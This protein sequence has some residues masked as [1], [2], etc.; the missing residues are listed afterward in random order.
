MSAPQLAVPKTSRIERKVKTPEFLAQVKLLR[1]EAAV[2]RNLEG[3]KQQRYV[4]EPRGTFNS[5]GD[6]RSEK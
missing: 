2:Q 4:F 1:E 5:G 6:E 3:P